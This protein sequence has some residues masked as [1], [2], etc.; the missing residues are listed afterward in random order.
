[1]HNTLITGLYIPAMVFEGQ[2]NRILWGDKCCLF[3]SLDNILLKE[4]KPKQQVKRKEKV[5]KRSRKKRWMNKDREKSCD[6]CNVFLWTQEGRHTLFNNFETAW[7][8]LFDMLQ[9]YATVAVCVCEITLNRMSVHMAL[10]WVIM[11]SWSS[12]FPSQQSS[13]THL[14]DGNHTEHI[15]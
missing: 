14:T 5:W 7:K 2:N 3:D 6:I 11:G 8:R 10:P 12:P 13:S 4:E 1:M 9:Y 15:I